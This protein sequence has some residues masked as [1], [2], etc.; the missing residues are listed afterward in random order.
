MEVLGKINLLKLNDN[1]TGTVGASPEDDFKLKVAAGAE[2]FA[3]GVP[4]AAVAVT[5]YEAIGG[6]EPTAKKTVLQSDEKGM[7]F[8]R[9]PSLSF[10]GPGKVVMLLD[11]SAYL[12][13]LTKAEKR[14]RAK[15]LALKRLALSKKQEFR[16][17]SLSQA[18][19][20]PLAVF[21]VD[22]D[23][24]DRPLSRNQATAGG[25]KQILSQR[26]FTLK[27]ASL[28]PSLALNAGEEALASLIQRR[29]PGVKRAIVGTAA[30][31]DAYQDQGR[32]IVKVNG[33]VKV[34]DLRSKKVIFEQQLKKTYTGSTLA[35]ARSAAF[36]QL[37]KTLGL[38]IAT[39]TK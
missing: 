4:R 25:I 29:V 21:V 37:G 6:S 27:T 23:E 34:L 10:V 30:V 38:R 39:G 1:L 32:H 7:V 17:T 33:T 31:E 28:P 20:L 22:L 5:Y 14:V 26:G 18:R 12:A 35:S 24:N 16:F 9:H 2:T 19:N 8:F 36:K 11:L 3:A 13:K 15:V